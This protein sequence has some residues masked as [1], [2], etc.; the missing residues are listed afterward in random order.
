M[1]ANTRILVVV[2]ATL[3]LF[4]AT[5]RFLV[6][7]H[8][9]APPP[10]VPSPDVAFGPPPG[11]MPDMVKMAESQAAMYELM[12]KRHL[13]P[14]LANFISQSR[15]Q[16]LDQTDTS[17]HFVIAF[18]G[19]SKL[20]ET[21]TIAADPAYKPAPADQERAAQ[22]GSQVYSPALTRK[23]TGEKSWSYTL[24]YHVSG[25]AVPAALRQKLRPASSRNSGGSH[26]FELI[27]RVYASESL[28]TA[29]DSWPLPD[30]NP[31]GELLGFEMISIISN[32]FAESFKVEELDTA[33]SLGADVPLAAVDF[34]EDAGRTWAG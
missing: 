27:P 16:I 19:H 8:G 3:F 29:Q 30:A 14:K 12:N 10:Q 13:G 9:T 32:Y 24:Q 31:Q 26:F 7:V 34:A 5:W 25:S 22:N 2:V 23:K 18:P 17:I 33:K 11:G 21:A 4:V 6:S 20:D 15:M 1:K 28:L